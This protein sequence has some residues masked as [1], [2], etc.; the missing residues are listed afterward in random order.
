MWVFK[1]DKIIN[2]EIEYVPGFFKIFDEVL[3]NAADNYSRKVPMTYIKVT[4]GDTI[5]V[6]ND[7]RPIPIE[8]LDK[9]QLYVPELIFGVLLTGSNFDDEEKR[10][11]GGRNGF[12]AKLTNV[13]SKEFIVEVCDGNRHFK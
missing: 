6:R 13:Y 3:V 11:V 8:M 2:K 5:S 9:H 12:G 4:I 7:G 1:N 10:V